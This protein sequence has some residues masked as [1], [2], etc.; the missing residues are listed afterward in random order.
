MEVSERGRDVFDAGTKQNREKLMGTR[1]GKCGHR[2]GG[3]RGG[4]WRWR[5]K[6]QRFF[7]SSFSPFSVWGQTHSQHQHHHC[8]E[9]EEPRV[10]ISTYYPYLNYPI[11]SSLTLSNPSNSTILFNASLT[12]T[13]YPEEDPTSTLGSPVFHGFSKNGTVRGELVYASRGTIQDFERLK[14][15]GIDLKGKIVLVQ[16]GGS[17]RGLKLKAAQE[18]GAIGCLIYSDPIG[19]GEI[20]EENGSKPYPFGPAREPSSVQRG[21]VQFLSIRPGDPLTPFEPAYNPSLPNSPKRLPVDDDK[22]ALNVPSIPSLPISYQDAIPLLE[23][24]KGKGIKREDRDGWKEGGLNWKGIEYWTGPS[25]P[26]QIVELKN[27][28][29]DETTKEIWNTMAIIP[30]VLKDEIVVIGNHNDAWTFGAGD[31]NSGTSSMYETVKAFSQLKKGGW[32]PF[33]TILLCSWDAE[34]Y[35]LIGSTEF[36]EDFTDY[37]RE[38]VVSYLNLDVSEFYLFPTYLLTCEIQD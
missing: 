22:D 19:D 13:P 17:F 20:T 14:R 37:L 18:S 6:I 16:Y 27:E 36:G 32:K 9:E 35:G 2:R 8:L 28:M 5:K 29:R 1:K 15:E 21:S 7:F 4:R 10:W 23:S 34:E 11:S 38:R 24:L 26:E 25:G 12:E 30:G 31:P 3:G 33:R